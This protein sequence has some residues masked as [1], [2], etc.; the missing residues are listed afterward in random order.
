MAR[1]FLPGC[2]YGELLSGSVY[3]TR[4]GEQEIPRVFASSLRNRLCDRGNSFSVR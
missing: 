3:G 4:T 1:G 2:Q